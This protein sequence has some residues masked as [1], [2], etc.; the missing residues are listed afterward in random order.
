MFFIV[1]VMLHFSTLCLINFQMT[2]RIHQLFTIKQFLSS[3]VLI[4][5]TGTLLL[6]VADNDSRCYS[7]K[8]Q[9][10]FMILSLK[11]TP[12]C[13]HLLSLWYL[14]SLENTKTNVFGVPDYLWILCETALGAQSSHWLY[15][16]MLLLTKYK[17][18]LTLNGNF[19]L[20]ITRIITVYPEGCTNVCRIFH[21]NPSK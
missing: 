20:R 21:G 5:S 16:N 7:L 9:W 19:V 18:Q 17:V 10:I 12:G 4:Q 6:N 2:A 11:Q 15:A 8:C 14:K 13:S 3:P 1:C